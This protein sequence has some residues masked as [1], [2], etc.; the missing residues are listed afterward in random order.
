MRSRPVGSVVAAVGGLAFVLL[1]SPAVP[2]ALAWQALAVVTFGA[3]VWF[4]VIRGPKREH[5]MPSRGAIRTYGF[6]VLAMVAAILLGARVLNGPLDR[7]TAVLPWVVLV[8]GAHFLPFAGAFELPIFRLVASA[9]VIV[10]LAGLVPTLSSDNAAAAGWTGVA[11]GLAL[12]LFA[13]VGPRF[14]ARPVARAS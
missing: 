14:S 6:S 7:P 4:V 2:G 9:L 13:A 8:V 11:A 10:G 12:L 1:N 3:I 5:A